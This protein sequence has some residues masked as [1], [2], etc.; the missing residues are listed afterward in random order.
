VYP[1][2]G[3]LDIP[4]SKI[5]AAA[6]C[7][8]RRDHAPYLKEIES[9]RYAITLGVLALTMVL[10]ST[11]TASAATMDD[12]AGSFRETCKNVRMRGDRLFA[13]CKNTY[14]QWQDTSLDDAYR[15]AGDITNVNGRLVCGQVGVMPRGDY[16]RTCRDLHMRFGTL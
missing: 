14:N 10:G 12:P 11:G 15:C 13:R 6:I 8:C 7:G 16:D 2:N 3:N 5:L 4:K 9:M 1:Q